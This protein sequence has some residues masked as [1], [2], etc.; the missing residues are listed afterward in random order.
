MRAW[1]ISTIV[2]AKLKLKRDGKVMVLVGVSWRRSTGAPTLRLE[3]HFVSDS[4]LLATS[5]SQDTEREDNGGAK[6]HDEIRIVHD[7]QKEIV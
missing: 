3:L 6:Q 1:Y 4:I 2:L 7:P 5:P